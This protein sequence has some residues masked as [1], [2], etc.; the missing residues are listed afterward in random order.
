MKRK[1]AALAAGTMALTMILTG[2]Q[3]SKGL[4]TDQ[5]KITQYDGI[6]V[7]QVEKAEE[8]TD[9]DVE[10][11]IDDTL[12]ANAEITEVTD[13]AVESG[14]TVN[15]DFVGTMD[16]EEFDGGSSEG[17]SL[18]IGSGTFID[19]FEDS[20]IGH[21][22]GDTYDWN[23]QFPEDYTEEL[24]GKDVTFTITVNSISTQKIPELTDEFV[25]KV[26]TTATTVEE[27]KEEVKAELE[28]AN[29]A[30]YESELISEIWTVL[31][32]NTEVIEYPEGRVDEVMAGVVDQYTM[33]AEQ[34]YGTDYETLIEEQM[35]TTVEEFE[36]QIED[37]A[38]QTVTQEMAIE[39]IADEERIKLSD[40]AYKEE[41]A[42]FAEENGYESADALAEAYDEEE[43]KL[44][45]LGNLV[46][47]WLIEHCIQVAE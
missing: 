40:E 12:Y 32:E 11:T 8:V 7:A 14:D 35:G 47:D 9:E 10:S 24:S 17:Y 1:L 43:L 4:E 31:L 46:N 27:Y 45:A 28:A 44:A 25:Q 26:S 19:G 20:V 18:T 38:K 42:S 6:E 23:G 22:V 36:V 34:Y 15:I 30:E 33:I 39:A 29:E 37:Y 41:L 5:I 2:C 3:G 16:G 21:N 13:R